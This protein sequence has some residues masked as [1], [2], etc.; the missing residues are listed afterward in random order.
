MQ[1]YV[2]WL[3]WGGRL[4]ANVIFLFITPETW[5]SLEYVRQIALLPFAAVMAVCA[6][7]SWVL[8]NRLGK[9]RYRI[10]RTIL[11]LTSTRICACGGFRDLTYAGERRSHIN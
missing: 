4:A 1:P 11:L 6:V 10:E 3:A 7:L 9:E 5:M 2:G 8:E